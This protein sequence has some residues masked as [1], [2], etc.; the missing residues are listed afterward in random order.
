M[1]AE[2]IAP[3]I[4]ESDTR[5]GACSIFRE[6]STFRTMLASTG[7][8]GMSGAHLIAVE[9]AELV[10]ALPS[11]MTASPTPSRQPKSA[12]VGVYSSDYGEL[13]HCRA[14]ISPSLWGLSLTCCVAGP[15]SPATH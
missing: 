2:E 14:P 10:V 4:S 12:D 3:C 7:L 5:R 11:A 13:G 6:S 9:H 15:S 1:S 8:T